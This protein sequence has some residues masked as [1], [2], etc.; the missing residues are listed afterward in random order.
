MYKEGQT[1][2]MSKIKMRG[3][4]YVASFLVQRGIKAVFLVPGGGNM[5]LVDAVGLAEG[6]EAVPNHH[7]QARALAAEAYSR[8]TEQIGVALVTSGPGATNAITGVGEA[9]AESAPLLVI[10]GQVKRS[11]LKLDS[12]LRQKGPQEV[13]IVA[14]VSGMTKY[15]VTVMDSAD[16]RYHLEKAFYLATTGRRGPVW[17]DIPLDI[18]G[19]PADPATMRGFDPAE[20]A[21]PAAQNLDDAAEQMIALINAA[22][23]PLFFI[24]HGVRLGGA[25]ALL[26]EMIEVFGIPVATSWNA[27]DLIPADHRL[28]FGKPSTVALRAANFAVQNCDLL[29]CIGV[30]LDN[31]V[32]AFNPGRFGRAARKVVVDVDPVELN[33]FTHHIDVRVLADAKDFLSAALAQSGALVPRDRSAWFARYAGWRER[34]ALNGGKPYPAQG[35]ISHFHLISAFSKA[36]PENAL[37]MTGGSGLAIESFWMTFL[38]KPGQRICTTSGLGSMG[39]GIPA[40]IGACIASGRQPCIGVESD[41]SL[42]MNLQELATLRGLNLPVT[43]FIINNGGYASIRNTQRNYFDG[44]YVG[45]G[46]EANLYMPDFVAV[47]RALGLDAMSIHDASDLD[48]GIQTALAHKGPILCD[49]HVTPNESLWPKAIAVPQP[50]GTMLSM[51]LEDMTP[52]LPR[53]ELRAQMLVPLAEESEK[54]IL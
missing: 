34:Y 7:E 40:M 30:R 52:L 14:M 41:G 21:A 16:L 43:I 39:Y 47:A 27:M 24:G 3:A 20:L 38:N 49:I 48:A 4:D 9:W 23:R 22:E 26:R 5:F 31:S 45:T 2:T 33:K 11:D 46:P 53:E 35:E 29:I 10:S 42:M 36:F 32:T 13:D 15:A 37:I 25:A 54:V 1:Q 6:L 28:N 17:I 12:G 8:V 19:G 51:P 44:R 18:Q 50:D